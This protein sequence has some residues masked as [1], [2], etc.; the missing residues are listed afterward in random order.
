V[1]RPEFAKK[2]ARQ[3]WDHRCTSRSEFAM[4]MA[5]QPVRRPDFVEKMAKLCLN[6]SLTHLSRA[7]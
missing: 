5:R 1:Q 4:K 7:Q 6:A 2:M 3:R